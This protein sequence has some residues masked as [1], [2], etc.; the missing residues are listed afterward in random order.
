MEEIIGEVWERYCKH[1]ELNTPHARFRPGDREGFYW[2]CLYCGGS[3]I[4]GEGNSPAY[5]EPIPSAPC[6]SAS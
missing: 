3:D 6:L 5:L 2:R 4:D 1:C